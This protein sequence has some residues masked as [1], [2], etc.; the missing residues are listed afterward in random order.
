MKATKKDLFNRLAALEAVQ[1]DAE[2]SA[3]VAS[4]LEL[5]DKR[6]AKSAER[7]A[8]K[9]AEKAEAREDIL[10]VIADAGEDGI[11]SKALAEALEVSV[12]AVAGRV[13]ALVDAGKV[14][15]EKVKVKN[16]NDKTTT[17]TVYKVAA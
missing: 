3:F 7:R 2:L 10:A 8:V 14:T 17:A 15:K 12:Q 5:L 11:T 1:N 16:D 9:K 4:E 13:K 6:A